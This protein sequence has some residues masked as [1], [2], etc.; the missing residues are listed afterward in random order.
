MTNVDFNYSLFLSQKKLWQ[1]SD[2]P[3]DFISSKLIDRDGNI[4]PDK[5]KSIR[6]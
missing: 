2:D 6:N 5:P 3:I 1:L 4:D